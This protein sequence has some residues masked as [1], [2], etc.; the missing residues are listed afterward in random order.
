MWQT[1]GTARALSMIGCAALAALLVVALCGFLGKLVFGPLR[2]R[3]EMLRA[4]TQFQLSDF[5]W[6]VVQLQVALVYSVRK[7]GVEQLGYF[8][9]VLGFLLLATVGMW[10]GAVSFMARAGVTQPLRRAVFILLLLPLT[11]ALMIGSSF[12]VVIMPASFYID[13]RVGG[14]LLTVYLGSSNLFRS[15]L[16]SLAGIAVGI[17]A[18][19]WGLRW[20][21]FWILADTSEPSRAD[22]EPT[23][24]HVD[25]P[26][27]TVATPGGA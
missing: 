6:L 13:Y 22:A 8:L 21:S 25:P 1:L 20:M 12:V 27:T 5:F 19:T 24:P 15:G 7:V 10:S 4:P 16:F 14:G 18:A 9:V 26:D 17:V 2:H 3:A 11:L 23:S